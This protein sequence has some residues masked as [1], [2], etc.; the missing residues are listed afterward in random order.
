MELKKWFEEIST[1]WTL[2]RRKD[3]FRSDFVDWRDLF[4]WDFLYIGD[5]IISMLGPTILAPSF[6]HSDRYYPPF[7]FDYL[8]THRER[9]QSTFRYFSVTVSTPF[10][11]TNRCLMRRPVRSTFCHRDM[12]GSLLLVKW[13]VEKDQVTRFKKS[14]NWSV[15]MVWCSGSG[16]LSVTPY[17]KNF[18]SSQQ[19]PVPKTCIPI[20]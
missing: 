13:V 3:W 14:V 5:E 10:M 1:L 9:R 20:N 15:W 6:L 2:L 18:V 11:W 7:T 16:K 12:S 17:P 4:L 19:Y 8:M